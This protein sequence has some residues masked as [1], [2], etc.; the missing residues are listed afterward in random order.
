MKLTKWQQ[1]FYYWEKFYSTLWY[2]VILVLEIFTAVTMETAVIS[3]VGLCRPCVNRRF[4]G[5]YAAA[6]S[7]RWFLASGLFYPEDRGDNSSE[8]SVH[9][10]DRVWHKGLLVKIKRTLPPRYFHLLKTYLHNRQFEV[11]VDEAVSQRFPISSGVPQGSVLG[12]M[13]EYGQ[14]ICK[15][16]WVGSRRWMCTWT[17]TLAGNIATGSEQI[18]L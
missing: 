10:F 9:L 7:S 2:H 14:R 15:L 4:G 18:S 11:K 3:D 1:Y 8:M 17:R 6:T 16:T 5:T 12:P 13:L